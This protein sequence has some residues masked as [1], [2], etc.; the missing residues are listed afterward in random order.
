MVINDGL[1]GKFNTYMEVITMILYK[2]I[3]DKTQYRGYYLH[4]KK[5]QIQKEKII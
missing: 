5:L 1:F 2:P 4:N 3:K